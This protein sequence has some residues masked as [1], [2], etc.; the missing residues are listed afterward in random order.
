MN[1]HDRCYIYVYEIILVEILEL[2]GTVAILTL[3]ESD[4]KLLLFRTVAIICYNRL[5]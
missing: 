3:L 2:F 1:N 5:Q 4:I